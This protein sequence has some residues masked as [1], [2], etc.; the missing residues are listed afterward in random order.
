MTEPDSSSSAR[1]LADGVLVINL[2]HR[3]DR[4]EH[5][6]IMARPVHSLGGWERIPAV[7]G[8]DLPGFGRRPWFRNRERDKAWAGR[9]GCTLSHRRAIEH[10]RDK[11]W[12][13]VLILED[14][15]QLGDSFEAG[16]K[17]FLNMDAAQ[18]VPW[19][20]CFLGLSQHVG[21]SFKIHDL[22]ASTAV[23]QIFGC[24]G[25]FA[26]IVKRESFDWIL[27]R[28]PTEQTIWEWTAR[29]RAIDR[30][31]ARNLSRHLKVIAVSPNLIGH[32]S[33][34]SD[35]G[36]HAGA[37]LMMQELATEN[38]HQVQPIGKIAFH[39][40]SHMLRMRLWFTQL[41]NLIQCCN[42]RYNGF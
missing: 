5:F 20:I 23:Y 18:P 13:S 14:D 4:M 24:T 9:A 12:Q 39:I 3:P 26:Y 30:W 2:D 36:L 17:I 15:I 7:Y 10:A 38:S 42:K 41:A 27:A 22:D 21:P 29:H 25:T 37:H 6:E 40:Q 34:F 32:Y 33:S 31:Y 8:V 16:V 19:H 11:G 35:I 28:L 1:R